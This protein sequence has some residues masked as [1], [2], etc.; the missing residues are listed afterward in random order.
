MVTTVQA[1]RVLR[2]SP[3][4]YQD[5]ADANMGIKFVDDTNFALGESGRMVIDEMIYDPI[6]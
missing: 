1:R 6:E 5:G 3:V 2:F 4:T